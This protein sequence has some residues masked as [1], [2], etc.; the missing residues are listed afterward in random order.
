MAAAAPLSPQ[1]SDARLRAAE[2]ALR[3]SEERFSRLFALGGETHYRRIL[4]T[5]QE[6]VWIIDEHNRTTFVNQAMAA[7]LDVPVD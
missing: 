4:E 5:A 1:R 2:A 7:M 3:A 6:G